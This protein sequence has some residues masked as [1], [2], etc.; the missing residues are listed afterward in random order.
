MAYEDFLAWTEENQHAEWVDGKVVVMSPAATR[1]Q[2]ILMFLVRLMYD[3]VYR[4]G[5]GQLLA[6]PFQM[7]LQTPPRG[8]EPDLLFVATEHLD[9]LTPTYLDG[10]ADLVVEI[11]SPESAQRDRVEKFGEYEAAGV[12]EYW[13]IDPLEERADFFRLDDGGRYTLVQEGS[14]GRFTS[15]V[16]AGLVVEAEWLWQ[17]PLPPAWE[18][19]EA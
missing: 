10:P 4:R 17:E 15:T 6:A 14:R 5:L 12:R 11:V 8:R 1:H 13:L 2:M 7:R 3:Y 9:R 18:L 16:I 19:G